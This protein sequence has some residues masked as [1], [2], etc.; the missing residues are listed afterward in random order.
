MEPENAFHRSPHIHAVAGKNACTLSAQ[1]TQRAAMACAMRCDAGCSALRWPMHG[2]A[3]WLL[4]PIYS[5]GMLQAGVADEPVTLLGVESPYTGILLGH[6]AV[7]AGIG[8]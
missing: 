6:A 7:H 2:T 1:I 5:L 8:R 3:L 4:L